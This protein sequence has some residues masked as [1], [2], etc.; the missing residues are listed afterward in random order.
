MIILF[1]ELKKI[2]KNDD[3]FSAQSKLCMIIMTKF[4]LK[5]KWW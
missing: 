4:E 5:K 1:D 2:S 3:D